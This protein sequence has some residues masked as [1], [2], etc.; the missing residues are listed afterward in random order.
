MERGVR[1]RTIVSRRHVKSTFSS[2]LDGN[3]KR[4]CEKGVDDK[5]AV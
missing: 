5:I 4:T 1:T 3:Q 2:F